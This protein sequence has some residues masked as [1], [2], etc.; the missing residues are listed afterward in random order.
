MKLAWETGAQFTVLL[1]EASAPIADV[2]ALISVFLR[3]QVPSSYAGAEESNAS[4]ASVMM[5]SP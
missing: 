2:L 4:L 3:Y 5:Y 1:F